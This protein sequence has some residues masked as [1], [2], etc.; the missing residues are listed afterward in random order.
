LTRKKLFALLCIA[1]QLLMAA[2]SSTSLATH[3]NVTASEATPTLST[4]QTTTIPSSVVARANLFVISQVGE[5]RFQKYISLDTLGTRY[6]EPQAAG[7]PTPG[8]A[9]LQRPYYLMAYSLQIPDK[10]FVEGKIVFAVDIEGNFI[11]EREPE[12]IP[13]PLKPGEWDF[14]IDEQAATGIARNAGLEAGIR[15]WKTSFHWF[16]A[17]FK[18]YVWTVESTTWA[19]ASGA[20]GRTVMIDAND[21]TVMRLLNWETVSGGIG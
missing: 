6:I 17:D 7:V 5:D 9:Y 11:R 16:A 20:G 4:S 12:G 10:P 14:P 13:N 18:T 2:C 1:G 15:D 8:S 21:G 3:S 19:S